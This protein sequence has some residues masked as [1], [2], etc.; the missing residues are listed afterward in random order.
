MGYGAT[1][2]APASGTRVA[3]LS[4][5]YADGVPWTAANR[6]SVWLGGALRPIVG[7]VSMDSISVDV[8][9]EAAVAVGDEAVLFG[10]LD[11]AGDTLPSH[12]VEDAAEA[13]GTLH[14]E[15]LVRVGG[16]VPRVTRST[17]LVD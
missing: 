4:L 17:G 8:G 11:E 14:Y 2:R 15:L 9:L 5:G 7:R 6:G 10:A 16:R 13:A 3:T 1:W 12:P